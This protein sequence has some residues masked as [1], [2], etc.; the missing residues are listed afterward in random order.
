MYQLFY[1]LEDQTIYQEMALYKVATA[2][3]GRYNTERVLN[4]LMH[5]LF[6]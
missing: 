6:Q 3:F 2:S 5:V 4:D 1:H